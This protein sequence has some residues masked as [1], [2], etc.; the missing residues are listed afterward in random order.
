[1]SRTFSCCIGNVGTGTDLVS[2]Y[3]HHYRHI[4][5]T[6]CKM[7]SFCFCRLLLTVIGNIWSSLRIS[8]ST[9]TST[10]LDNQEMLNNLVCLCYVSSNSII[11]SGRWTSSEEEWAATGPPQGDQQQRCAS[12][13]TT[14]QAHQT[15]HC[16]VR[17][18]LGRW[19]GRR[20]GIICEKHSCNYHL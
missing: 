17:V 3:H 8:K 18:W 12:E 13:V 11:P 14:N 2:F 19:G 16:S 7:C 4:F 15:H 1:M 20:A 10:W 6:I 5:S 9:V